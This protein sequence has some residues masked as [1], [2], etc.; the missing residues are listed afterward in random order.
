MRL[1]GVH[2][3]HDALGIEF[4]AA[5]P[6]GVDG[7][8]GGRIRIQRRGGEEEEG[9]ESATARRGWGIIR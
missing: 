7:V 3:I 6:A 2:E 4:A 8:V 9:A 5:R 1:V